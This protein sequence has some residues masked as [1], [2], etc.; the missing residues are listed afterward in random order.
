MIIQ[1]VLLP[2]TERKTLEA[3][4]AWKKERELLN[5]SQGFAK[6]GAHNRALCIREG[7]RKEYAPSITAVPGPER[8]TE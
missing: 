3:K 8:I 6:D 5:T 1:S 4:T 2:D 7:F